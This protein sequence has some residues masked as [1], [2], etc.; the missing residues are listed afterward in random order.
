[1]QTS[2]R[3]TY[4]QT[5]MCM[6][7]EVEQEM[8]A[9]LFFSMEQVVSSSH[10]KKLGR[11]GAAESRRGGLPNETQTRWEITERLC[12]RREASFIGKNILA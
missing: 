9:F 11:S 10:Y 12:N 2:L 4:V 8:N 6:P 3:A 1:M 7:K 5:C